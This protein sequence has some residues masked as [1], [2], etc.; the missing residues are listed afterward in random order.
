MWNRQTVWLFAWLTVWAAVDIRRRSVSLHQIL[1]VMILG[2]FWQL[3][4]EAF[5]TWT[6]AGGLAVGGLFWLFARLSAGR[7]GE[8]DAL[9]MVCLGLY[10]GLWKSLAVVLA[11]LFL[12]SGAALYLLLIRKKPSRT[13]MPFLPFLAAGFLIVGII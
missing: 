1:F 11:A 13:A 8:G 3:W 5:F 6:T 2:V 7:L 9:V 10:L 4:K 12:A